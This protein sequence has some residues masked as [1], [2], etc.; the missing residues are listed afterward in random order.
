MKT[1]IYIDGYNLYYGV[2]KH[3]AYK[4]LNVYTLFEALVKEND[5]LCQLVHCGFYTSLTKARVSTRGEKSV[6]SQQ[7]YHRALESIHT[8]PVKI[9]CHKHSLDAKPLMCA[10][11]GRSPDKAQRAWV[12][13]TSEKK[14]DVA[15]ALDAYRMAASGN[16]DQIVFVTNDTD[17]EPALKAIRDDFPSIRRGVIVPRKEGAARP[18]SADLRAATHWMRS[19]VADRELMAHQFPNRV[20]TRK[21]PAD[22][23]DYW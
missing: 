5:P 21:K 14:T 6:Q 4:W 20:P 8:P 7:V 23:P 2:L 3:S 18:A 17:H 22:K 12:W 9:T 15:M 10:E 16:A 1:A 13:Q 11:N 19:H